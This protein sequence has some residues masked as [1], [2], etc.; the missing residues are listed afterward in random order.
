[1]LQKLC[2]EIPIADTL[3]RDI[4]NPEAEDDKEEIEVMIVLNM[5]ANSK[6]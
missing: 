1:M 4:E 6:S 3:N 5:S 2:S